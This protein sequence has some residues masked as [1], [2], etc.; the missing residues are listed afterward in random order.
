[1]AKR[2]STR[3]RRGTVAAVA[4]ALGSLGAA[5][6][7]APVAADPPPTAAGNIL[8]GFRLDR[9]GDFHVIHLDAATTIGPRLPITGTNLSGINDRRD[10]A[11]L[12]EDRSRVVRNHLTLQIAWAAD[13]TN[14]ALPAFLDTARHIAAQSTPM[15]Q[16]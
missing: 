4:L 7:A 13:N 3:V 9:D 1:M 16:P 5:G 12:Y 14:S 10:I 15:V 8:H 11:G 6:T 2:T